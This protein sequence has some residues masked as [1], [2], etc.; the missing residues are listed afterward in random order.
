MSLTKYKIINISVGKVKE[1]GPKKVK[2][3]MYKNP[4]SSLK[5]YKDHLPGDEVYAVQSH[6]GPDRI[7]HHYSTT[8]FEHFKKIFPDRKDLFVP[9]SYGENITTDELTE[10]DL[11]IGDIFRLGTA[12]VQVT[13]E[14]KPCGT[15]D[16]CY[17]FKGILKEVI[18]S[19]KYG[20]FYRVLEEGE[21]ILGDFLEF[22]ERIHPEFNLD[23]VIYE[24]FQAGVDKD[25][26]FLEKLSKC[27]EYSVRER[28][29]IIKKIL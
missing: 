23:R 5:I 19:R 1:V 28:D 29:R 20:W 6:G 17:G 11:C 16:Y 12:L 4:V 25:I 13:Q 3:A 8:N 18:S 10:K 27:P 9:A 22:Q 7:V 24:K 26:A 2:T 15:I 14:R 21:V